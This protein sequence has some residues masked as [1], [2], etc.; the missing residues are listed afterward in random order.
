M[1]ARPG[2]V[3]RARLELVDVDGDLDVD[4]IVGAFGLQVLK[5]AGDGTFPDVV[6]VSTT[7]NVWDLDVGDVDKDGDLDLLVASESRQ[8]VAWFAAEDDGYG[9]E[10]QAGSGLSYPHDVAPADLDGDG[11]IDLATA[12]WLGERLA[13]FENGLQSPDAGVAD[14]GALLVLI[15]LIL[16]GIGMY[17]LRTGSGR[18]LLTAGLWISVLLLAAEL[19]A[20]WAMS[21]KPD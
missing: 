10:Q 8:Y 18:G 15:A 6:T 1:L 14:A 5:N 2:V 3:T 11:D 16:G 20:V 7:L 21:A 19:V 9:A 12:E 17:R 13:W 4:I